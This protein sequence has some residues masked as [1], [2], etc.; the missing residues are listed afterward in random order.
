MLRDRAAAWQRPFL[1]VLAANDE[2]GKTYCARHKPTS[3][4]T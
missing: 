4:G 2:A 1:I 3:A